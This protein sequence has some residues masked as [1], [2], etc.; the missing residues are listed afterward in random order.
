[1]IHY[2][3]I[4]VDRGE[5]I[6][7]LEVE[8]KEGETL[9]GLEERMHVVEHELIVK[10]TGMALARL[11]EERDRD[12]EKDGRDASGSTISLRGRRLSHKMHCRE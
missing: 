1:M 5:P 2:V 4:A 6:V 7:V 10:G 8:M 3:V 12:K 11:W 9:E